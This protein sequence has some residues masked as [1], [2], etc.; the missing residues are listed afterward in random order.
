MLAQQ[1]YEM[2]QVKLKVKIHN[3]NR[4]LDSKKI[5]DKFAEDGQKLGM[6]IRDPK[7]PST[8]NIMVKASQK[9]LL[10]YI[11]KLEGK[12]WEDR[13]VKVQFMFLQDE[14]FYDSVDE[15]Y[16]AI[17]EQAAPDAPEV[18]EEK[19]ELKD[20]A[21]EDDDLGFVVSST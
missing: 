14:A 11:A 5:R 8:Q 15:A 13:R 17:N 21:D 18:E 9:E 7:N 19:T 1:K 12:K 20:D 6:L 4:K 2:E 3:V 10:V 16:A